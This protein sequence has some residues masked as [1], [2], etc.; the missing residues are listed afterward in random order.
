MKNILK[1]LKTSFKYATD[2]VG[3]IKENPALNVGLPK[4]DVPEKDPAHIFTKHEIDIILKDLI[5]TMLFIML[6]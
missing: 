2:V 6:F 1:V 5:K 3:F 4:Y